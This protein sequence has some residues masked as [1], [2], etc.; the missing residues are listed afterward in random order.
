MLGFRVRPPVYRAAQR[1][2]KRDFGPNAPIIVPLA[3]ACCA[4]AGAFGRFFAPQTADICF[5][6]VNYLVHGALLH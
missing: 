6:G 3:P 2:A 1:N 4:A 5:H